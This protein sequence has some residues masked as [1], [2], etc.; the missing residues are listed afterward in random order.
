MNMQI[1]NPFEEFENLLERYNKSGGKNL[2]KQYSTDLSFADW[3][4]S[5]DIEEAEGDRYQS[6]LITLVIAGGIPGYA[7][8]FMP[9]FRHRQYCRVRTGSAETGRGIS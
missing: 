8:F 5:V 2:G 7:A 9:K 1:W 6:Q 3:A 4:P